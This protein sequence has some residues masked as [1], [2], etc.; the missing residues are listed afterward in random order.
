MLDFD[1]LFQFGSVCSYWWQFY[2][3]YWKNFLASQEPLLVQKS[4]ISEKHFSLISLPHQKVY[5]SKMFNNFF[6]F[7][8]QGS[9]SGYFI[10]TCRNNNSFTLINPFTRRK[11]QI[12][13]STFKV[14]YS[15]FF[16][17]VLLAFVRGSNEFILVVSCRNSHD[18]YVYKS[19]NFG[20]VTYST[21]QKVVDF[22]VLHNTIYVVTDKANIG[23]LN[24]NSRDI[25]FLELKGTPSVTYTRY[26]HVRLVSCD[27][28]LLVLNFLSKESFNVYKIDFSTMDYVKLETLGDLALFYAPR[29]KYYAL[30]N[31]GRWGYEKN[32]VHV[33]DLPCH[34]YRVYKGD[35][36]KM[37]EIILPF[38]IASHYS[39]QDEPYLDWCFRHLHYEVDYSFV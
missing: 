26:S 11:I 22:V 5:H 17:H 25:H 23:I 20:W 35:D 21:L 4:S 37:P 29:R 14:D 24:L 38:F 27:G 18:L 36:N 19:Q 34:K 2:K 8:Y 6:R 32:S 1:D 7:A 9:S 33:I 10:M 16:C 30:S 13:N 28:Q 15:S 12:K 39:Y 3:I 31:P